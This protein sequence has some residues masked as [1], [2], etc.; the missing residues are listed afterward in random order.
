MNTHLSDSWRRYFSIG[1]FGEVSPKT[2]RALV[3]L[4]FVSTGLELSKV[5]LRIKPLRMGQLLCD[6]MHTASRRCKAHLRMVAWYLRCFD[7][8]SAPWCFWGLF[9]LDPQAAPSIN[10]PSQKLLAKK[11]G[12]SFEPPP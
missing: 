9:L 12:G 8:R 7:F 1:L 2:L 4:P 3:I 11:V 10:H 5:P 6:W